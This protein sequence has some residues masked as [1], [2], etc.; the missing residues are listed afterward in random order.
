[1]RKRGKAISLHAGI[2]MSIVIQ[3][4]ADFFNDGISVQKLLGNSFCRYHYF[5]ETAD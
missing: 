1:M 4:D 2:E 5:L 3:T